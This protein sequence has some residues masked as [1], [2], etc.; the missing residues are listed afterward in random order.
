MIDILSLFLFHQII[1]EIFENDNHLK[2]IEYIIS[3]A[4]IHA[5][6]HRLSYYSHSL[7]TMKEIVET[8][9]VGAKSPHHS[10]FLM[11][12]LAVVRVEGSLL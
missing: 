8:F 4:C 9:D 11:S 6:H 7:E 1:E 10:F 2:I 5:T 3:G 12:F